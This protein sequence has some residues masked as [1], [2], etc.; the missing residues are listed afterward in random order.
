MNNL[1]MS[2]ESFG[3]YV[4]QGTKMLFQSNSQDL[5]EIADYSSQSE[6]MTHCR[7]NNNFLTGV[8]CDCTIIESTELH[9]AN[10]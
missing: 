3:S 6:A 1:P 7:A 9:T 2:K 4:V 5:I 8:G 10:S